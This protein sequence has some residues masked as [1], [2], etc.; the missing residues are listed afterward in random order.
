V[1]SLCGQ[2]KAKGAGV[3]VYLKIGAYHVKKEYIQYLKNDGDQYCAHF[4]EGGHAQT[5]TLTKEEGT[6][7]L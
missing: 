4:G 3:M 2:N 6:A 7:L 5:A 1:T